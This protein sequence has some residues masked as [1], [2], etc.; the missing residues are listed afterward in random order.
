MAWLLCL[1]LTGPNEIRELIYRA[2]VHGQIDASLGALRNMLRE[3][4]DQ[5]EHDA[6]VRAM[7]IIKYPRGPVPIIRDGRGL[8]EILTEPDGLM[9]ARGITYLLVAGVWIEPGDWLEDYFVLRI[10]ASRMDTESMLGHPRPFTL[11]GLAE[12]L[13]TGDLLIL[14]DAPLP[15]VLSFVSQKAG[16]NYF[17]DPQISRT[18]SGSFPIGDWT[19]LLIRICEAYSVAFTRHGENAIF[20]TLSTLNRRGE[21]LMGQGERVEDLYSFLRD[22]ADRFG[23]ELL[24]DDS[25]SGQV[26]YSQFED[27]PWEEILE[28]LAITNGF[29]WSLVEED[30]EKPKLVVQKQ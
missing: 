28:C 1:M 19:T 8:P 18:V 20:H 10:S 17:I 30:G 13:P 15:I 4:G 25:L 14:R 27:Q 22:I 23:L 3:T 21:M 29:S 6:I 7:A 5:D 2:E 11:A 9:R 16:L 24:F 12:T 26:I